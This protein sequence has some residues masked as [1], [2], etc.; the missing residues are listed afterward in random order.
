[1]K[2]KLQYISQGLNLK[3]QKQNIQNALD[4]GADWIQVRWKNASEKELRIL[5]ETTRIWCTGYD[6][7]CIIND[8][9]HIAKETD[10]DGVHLGLNDDSIQKART[11]LGKGKIIGGTANT[12]NDVIQRIREQCDYIGLGPFRFT[13]TKSNLS[14]VLGIKGY[15]SVIQQLKTLDIAVPPVYAIGG[16]EYNDIAELMQ[17]GISGI[18]VSGM[19]T[20]KPDCIIKI[21]NQ[22]K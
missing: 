15:V 2:N 1:M 21:L 13:A 7:V 12:L 16:I 14:P 3:E 10:A 19:I 18:A 5:S 9:I 4:H 6:A 8:H 20:Q 17:T 22:L 11:L